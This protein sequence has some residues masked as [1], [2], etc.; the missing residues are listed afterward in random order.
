ME[1]LTKDNLFTKQKNWSIIKTRN[2]K[3]SRSTKNDSYREFMVGENEQKL[4]LE[5][6][7]GVELLN[8]EQVIP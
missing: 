7:D 6:S 3:K 8:N 2:T 5:G 4:S 1:I